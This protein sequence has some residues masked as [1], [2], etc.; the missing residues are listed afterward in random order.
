MAAG[1]TYEPILTTTLGSAQASIT[2]SSI[3]QS[4]TDLVLIGYVKRTANSDT[5]MQ[6]NGNTGA[7]YSYTLLF[8]N[9]SSAS[10]YRISS[11]SQWELG[12]QPATSPTTLIA[13]FQNYSNSTTFKTVL[14]RV[15]ASAGDVGV[16]ANRCST[17]DPITSMLIFQSAG[18]LD[19]GSTFTL[20]GIKAA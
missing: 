12:Y 17:T 19:T 5:Q 4:Y 9:G 6:I 1:A 14:S 10:G 16:Y 18:N 11:A 3:S 2:F 15:N 13:N 7:A 8:G 20:Y